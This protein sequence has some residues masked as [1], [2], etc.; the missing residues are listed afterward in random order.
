MKNYILFLF[1]IVTLIGN[2]QI[3]TNDSKDEKK[4][5][6]KVEKTETRAKTGTEIYFGVSPAY[7]YRTLEIN[8]NLFGQSIG[9]RENETGKWTT[10]FNAGVRNK[11]N[12]FLKLEIG[13]GYSSNK[14]AYDFTESDSVFRYI[15]TYRHI[16]FPIRMAYTFGDDI[17]FYGALGIIPKAFMSMKRE[18]TVLDINN[19]EETIKTIERDKF[20]MFLIDAVAT[21]GTQ[22]KFNQHYGVFVMAEARRQLNNTFNS[23]SAHN[24]KPYTLGFNIGIEVYL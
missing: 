2:T 20:N 22:I 1:S 14:E 10:G 18:V 15:N 24:R 4:K 12:N 9:Y 17:S 16:S 7:T 23:Q 3:I 21:I 5:P 11:I 6:I 8:D 19:N 13:V